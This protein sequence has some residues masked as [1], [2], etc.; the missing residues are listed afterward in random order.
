MKKTLVFFLG[1]MCLLLLGACGPSAEV[2]AGAVSGTLVALPTQTAFPTYTPFA[3]YTPYPTYTPAPT[4]TAVIKIV[5]PTATSTPEYTPTITQTPTTTP[6]ITPT[7]DQLKTDKGPGF[8]LVGT[9]IAPGV[10]RSMGSSDSCY[11]EIDTATGDII[12]NHFGMAGGTMY[13]PT[14]AFQVQLD[15]ECGRWTFL[16]NP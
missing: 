14:S 3:T 10:W 15:P 4:Q 6:T 9:D 13:I 2:V 12:N 5:T 8:Y 7:V 11:W 16:N 1:V